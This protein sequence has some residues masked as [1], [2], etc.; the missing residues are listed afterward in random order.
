[1]EDARLPEPRWGLQVFHGSGRDL[2]GV[3]ERDYYPARNI[4]YPA[5]GEQGWELP[6]LRR[7]V[8]HSAPGANIPAL[9]AL[10][11]RRTRT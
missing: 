2:I 6:S 3:I 1:M 10:P 4:H 8:I 9:S 7:G 5:F 11:P